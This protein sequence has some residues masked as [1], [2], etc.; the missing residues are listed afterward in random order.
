M[1]H[2][3]LPFECGAG[4]ARDAQHDELIMDAWQ[5]AFEFKV[6]AKRVDPFGQRRMVA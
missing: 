5:Y 6:E 4:R 1:L 3:I 2:M